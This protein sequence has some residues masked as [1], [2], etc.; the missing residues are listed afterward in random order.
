[1][2]VD[3]DRHQRSIFGVGCPNITDTKDPL[4]GVK[5]AIFGVD[6]LKPTDTI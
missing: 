5:Q 3:V 1:V 6:W 2:S 4:C